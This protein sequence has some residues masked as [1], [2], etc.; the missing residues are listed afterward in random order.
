MSINI[1]RLLT[2]IKEMKT[3]SQERQQQQAANATCLVNVQRLQA[4]LRAAL[5]PSKPLIPVANPDPPP[6]PVVPVPPT[7]PTP[8]MIPVVPVPPSA[9]PGLPVDS[10]LPVRARWVRLA[11]TVGSEYLN[12]EGLYVYDGN[13]VDLTPRIDAAASTVS[14][15]YS[16]SHFPV[17]NVWDGNPRTFVLTTDT[18]DAYVELDFA[19]PQTIARVHIQNRSD[20][21]QTRLLGSALILYDDTRREVARFPID[22]VAKVYSVWVT[23]QGCRLDPALT[24]K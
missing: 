23:P 20:C 15:N 22:F 11:R 18:A 8:P 4:Q 21:C 13:G 16:A 10:L 19:T 9:P 2:R 5:N 6:Y 7:E 14:P 12:V 17:S 24:T 1:A 3:E